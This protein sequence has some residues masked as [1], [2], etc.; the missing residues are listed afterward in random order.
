MKITNFLI[1]FLFFPF[2]GVCQTGSKEFEEKLIKEKNYQEVKFFEVPEGGFSLVDRFPMYPNGKEG[3]NE[4]LNKNLTYPAEALEKRI[5]G[6]VL[7]GFTIE[8]DGTIGNVK[9][10]QN[11][12]PLLDE[13]AVRIINLM[14]NWLPG[15]QRGKPVKVQLEQTIHFQ[16]P[17]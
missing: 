3:I 6:T 8:E 2:L 15:I 13:E 16:L 9:V 10:I 1:A 12:H 7:L 11:V 14:D 5:K 4:Y 17:Q